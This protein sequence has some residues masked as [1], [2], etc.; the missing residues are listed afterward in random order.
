MGL[1][2]VTGHSGNAHISAVDVANF[3]A[4]IFGSGTYVLPTGTQFQAVVESN[5]TVNISGGEMII[6]G[7]HI[8]MPYAEVHPVSI[9]NGTA[10]VNRADLIVIRY[11]NDFETGVENVEFAVIEG[12][13]TDGTP[14]LP[15]Y[16]TGDLL[17]GG[18]AVHEE[19]LYKIP[20]NG[21]TIGE[22]ERL[23]SEMH[24]LD[25]AM[26]F[27]GWN[28]ISSK[29]EDTPQ[30]WKELGTGIWMID[31]P[32][33]INGQPSQRGFLYNTVC[34]EEVAQ[35]FIVQASG[36]TFRRNANGIGWYGN[37][38][39]EGKWVSV[40][41]GNTAPFDAG[42]YIGSGVYGV[43][44]PNKLT[45][46]FYPKFVVVF[47]D[48]NFMFMQRY[49]ADAYYVFANSTGGESTYAKKNVTT[50]DNNSVSWY[51]K[52]GTAYHSGEKL[53]MN[54]SGVYYFYAAWG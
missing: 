52:A 32:D 24:G 43:D 31:L 17:S 21:L 35:K 41:D 13:E 48:S 14:I 28:P 38:W 44:N 53:Q 11:T 54:E 10:G 20:I 27:K 46:N 26:V 50:W 4:G 22:P 7:R 9:S 2:L 12:T 47:W 5:N 42:S 33:R 23:I 8:R 40:Y 25:N 29:A 49:K 51:L 16:Q 39:R 36:E 1:H 45:F 37:D 34:A 30:K 15:T 3:N 18:C 19:P 6:Q